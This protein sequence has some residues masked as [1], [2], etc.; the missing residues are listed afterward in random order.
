MAIQSLWNAAKSVLRRKFIA[1]K[2]YLKKEKKISN[3]QP[4]LTPKV[5][6]ERATNKPQS[7][8]KERN[9]KNWGRNKSN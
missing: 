8:W 3:E 4:N 2:S 6:R 7:Q 1:I 5:T 9:H